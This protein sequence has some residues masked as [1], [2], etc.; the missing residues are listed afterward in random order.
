MHGPRKDHMDAVYQILRYLKTT[1]RKGLI[2]QK[3]SHL[4][5]ECYYDW[6]STLGYYMFVGNNLI[7]LK[8]KK[9]SVAARSTFEIKYRA[10]ALRVA[11]MLWLKDLLT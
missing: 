8:S 11:K 7:S 9:Q 10:M 1:P 6:R 3:N 4:S 5:I 2:F